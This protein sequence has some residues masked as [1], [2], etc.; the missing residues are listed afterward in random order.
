MRKKIRALVD[1]ANRPP[2]IPEVELMSLV[3]YCL[4]DLKLSGYFYAQADPAQ[5]YT[6]S[7]LRIERVSKA[8]LKE[9]IPSYNETMGNILPNKRSILAE[10]D[11][12]IIIRALFHALREMAYD[13]KYFDSW[14]A[15][16]T[17]IY[18]IKQYRPELLHDFI[19]DSEIAISRELYEN[20]KLFVETEFK[21]ATQ[22]MPSTE[23][24]AYFDV[25]KRWPQGYPPKKEDYLL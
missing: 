22:A 23:V 9:A 7:P 4:Q 16:I 11:L 5:L 3:C 21:E 19:D 8:V 15:Y 6:L 20:P 1:Y 12:D 25:Y 18:Q 24:L 10:V 14:L 17:A 13:W 2:T